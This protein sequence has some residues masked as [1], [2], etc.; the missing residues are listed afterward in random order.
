MCQA[1]S[2]YMC[3]F[4]FCMIFFIIILFSDFSALHSVQNLITYEEN[5]C[6]VLTTLDMTYEEKCITL[7]MKHSCVDGI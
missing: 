5:K 3:F 1:T 6:S 7:V 4:A 2:V